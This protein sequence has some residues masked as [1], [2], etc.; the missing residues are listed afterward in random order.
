MDNVPL[1]KLE[2]AR[3]EAKKCIAKI[4]NGEEA[5]DMERM[6]RLVQK[7][8]RECMAALESDPHHVVAFECIGNAL[9]SQSEENVSIL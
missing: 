3:D 7:Q 9:Y 5:I 6:G 2:I 4:R 1:D 8:L